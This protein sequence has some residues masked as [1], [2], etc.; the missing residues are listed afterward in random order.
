MTRALLFSLL[1]AGP[2]LATQELIAWG[3]WRNRGLEAAFRQFELEHPE[4]ELTTSAASSGR[5]DPQKLM[6]AIA[7]GSPPALLI[8]D[9][10]SVGSSPSDN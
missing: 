3:A 8:Q 5:M 6:C 7:G 9:R 10:F 1:L 2:T 4:W